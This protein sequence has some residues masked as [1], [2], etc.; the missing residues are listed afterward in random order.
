MYRHSI[1]HAKNCSHGLAALALVLLATAPASAAL[2]GKYDAGLGV[3]TNGVNVTQWNSQVG[4]YNLTNTN[5]PI[6]TLFATPNGKPVIE[7]QNNDALAGPATA[8]TGFPLAGATSLTAAI[9]FKPT[10]V[11]NNDPA[12][13]NFWGHP[14]LASGDQGGGAPDWGFGWGPDGGGLNKIWFGVGEDTGGVTPTVTATGANLNGWW[15][16]VGTWNGASGVSAY[17][18]N[19]TGGLVESNTLATPLATAPRV[20]VGFATAGERPNVLNRSFDGQ[21]AAIE[22]Y[23]NGVDGAGANAIAAA[24]TSTYFAGTPVTPLSL[25]V[26]TTTGLIT[27]RNPNA[28]TALTADYYEIRSPGGQLLPGTWN[29]LDAQNFDAVDG[30]DAGTTAGDSPGEGW[31]KAV[32]VGTGLLAEYYLDEDGSTIP[33]DP[34]IPLGNGY[35]PAIAGV[36]N[37]GDL[38]FNYALPNGSFINGSVVYV[39]GAPA[40]PGD[41]NNNGTVDTADY[42]LW[43]NGGPLQ[44]EVDTPGVVNDAD[45]TAW[46]ARFGNVSGSGSSLEAAVPEP[47]AWIS[48]LLAAMALYGGRRY[49]D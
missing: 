5:T 14:Q 49:K 43:R 48:A 31:D 45:Y 40:V 12:N 39:A 33:A 34:D 46:R 15:I 2:V 19:Q 37:P 6:Q 30:P 47:A 32:G 27:L 3:T 42:V 25:L 7:F 35:N 26:N 22:L 20:D 1:L 29:S 41:Y 17:L 13:T 28:S 44:N 36:G 10:A 9:V 38:V 18:Y 8:P 21:I 23:D 11:N 4:T 16:A 24:L